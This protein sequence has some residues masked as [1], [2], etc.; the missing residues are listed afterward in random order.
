MQLRCRRS[1]FVTGCSAL[2]RGGG[3]VA[4]SAATRERACV[5][6]RA[7]R[8]GRPQELAADAVSAGG[9]AGPLRVG[10][11][12]SGRLALGSAASDPRLRRAGGAA[13]RRRRLDRRRHGDRQGWQT[14]A[15]V[16]RQYSGT[17][18]KIGNC[19]ITVSVHAVGERGTRSP[20]LARR[21]SKRRSSDGS[22]RC[23]RRAVSQARG[24]RRP[25]S[26]PAWPKQKPSVG[27]EPTALLLTIER[28]G[29]NSGQGGEPRARK[30][31]KKRESAEDE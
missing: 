17:L 15:G 10:A 24:V 20:R 28:R 7:D 1:R 18:G 2:L 21:S 25:G 26:V 27:L 6:A 19:Q 30:P 13:D 11:A 5:R 3:A 9:V 22:T 23:L 31:R 29:G 12:V 8:A 14:L 4:A 16:K